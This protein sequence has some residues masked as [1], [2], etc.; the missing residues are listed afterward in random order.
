[1]NFI[2]PPKISIV[3]PSFNQGKYLEQTI[4]SVI[5]QK[6]P[7]LEYIIIDGGSTDNSVEIIK[8]YEKYLTYWVSEPDAGQYDAV[9][10]GFSKT[11]GEIMA[12]LN[13]DDQYCPW[14]LRVVGDIFGQLSGADWLTSEFVLRN[15][16]RG[17]V[18]LCYK[19]K[20]HS[21]KRY[22]R[23]WIMNNQL[24]GEWI[25]QESTFWRRRLWE[26]VGNKIDQRYKLAA[27]FDL[28]A[29]FWKHS[30]LFMVN[31]PLSIVRKHEGRRSEIYKEQY[32]KEA[33][34]SLADEGGRILSKWEV[35]FIRLFSSIPLVRRFFHS[36]VH[37]VRL[38][39]KNNMWKKVTGKVL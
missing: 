39:I 37:L 13:S 26:Q 9:N 29:K 38:D 2:K 16:Y 14:S 12:W 31:V 8:K 11:T 27:D 28:W 7:N 15:N 22:F 36:T 30:K 21:C 32:I 19:V 35:L 3:T 33:I 6:Y 17:L 18:Y 24:S 34:V 23:R 4:L 10:K 1:M 25:T 5:G 20:R